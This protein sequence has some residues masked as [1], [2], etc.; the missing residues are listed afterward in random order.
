MNF[1]T[2][3]IL[4]LWSSE[5]ILEMGI[6]AMKLLCNG[7]RKERWTTKCSTSSQQTNIKAKIIRI[8]WDQ[9]TLNYQSI[10]H[11]NSRSEIK[12]K[13]SKVV[14]LFD[15]TVVAIWFSMPICQPKVKNTIQSVFHITLMPQGSTEGPQM[16][17]RPSLR[18]RPKCFNKTEI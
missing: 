18:R 1:R 17:D 9:P 16:C 13:N 14:P 3:L 6:E 12:G 10:I 4:I 5:R 11:K 15:I 2:R 7:K 8:S